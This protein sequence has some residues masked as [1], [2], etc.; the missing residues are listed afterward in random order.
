MKQ[1]STENGNVKNGKKT[2]QGLG[3]DKPAGLRTTLVVMLLA[4]GLFLGGAVQDRRVAVQDENPVMALLKTL[5]V[6]K[7]VRQG[8]LTIIPVYMEKVRDKTGYVTLEEAL[9]R[10][11][12]EIDELEGGRVPQVRITSLS[13]TP[14]YLMGGE[15]LTGC[16]QDR[17]MARDLLLGPGTKDLIVPVFCV[18]HGRWTSNSSSFFSKEN[19][20]TYSMRKTAQAR[21]VGA[22]SE[23]WNKVAEQNRKMGVNS[24]T[25]AYQ[26]AYDKEENKTRIAAIEKEM[27]RVPKLYKDTVGVVIGLGEDIIGADIFANP[28]LFEKQWPKI[29]RAS[30]LSSLDHGRGG[31][32]SQ[33][34]AARFLKSFGFMRY[35]MEKGLD[36][37]VEYSAADS[38]A[39]ISCLA[40]RQ[41]VIHLAGFP[42]DGKRMKVMEEGIRMQRRIREPDLLQRRGPRDTQI[43]MGND[44]G[45]PVYR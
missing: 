31:T 25:S 8:A 45:R 37:G 10:Q 3:R 24:P 30:A 18:E 11:W 36:M 17:I 43:P 38:L 21:D 41:G 33:E 29:L 1:Q 40:A 15:I 35:R 4:L 20:G 26:D 44:E 34:E 14:I 27:G 22:Q 5:E 6:G 7:A 13:K 28:G 23:I 39:F 32:V 9:K 42:Q 12:I 16:K 2:E 19:I